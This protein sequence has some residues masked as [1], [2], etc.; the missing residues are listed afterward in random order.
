MT[1][2]SAEW[3]INN[4]HN[5]IEIEFSGKPSA[6][7][8]TRM[9]SAG[10]RWS[11][12]SGV[13][14]ARDNPRTRQ[15]AGE[16][17][18]QGADVGE[19]LSYAEQMQAKKERVEARQERL[20]E[21]IERKEAEADNRFDRAHD[22]ASV[23]PFGQPILIGHHSEKRDR[24]YRAKIDNNMRKGVE[25]QEEA[26]ELG[27]RLDGSR[28]LAA[29]AEDPGAV[30]RKIDKFE[31]ELRKIKRNEQ[32]YSKE[33]Y[34]ALVAK[35]DEMINYWKKILED[36]GGLRVTKNDVKVGDEVRFCGGWSKVVRINAKSVTIDNWLDVKGW[37]Y[38]APYD[39][40]TG[41]R[42]PEE[43]AESPEVKA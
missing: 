11:S 22:M 20:E 29:K 24:N 7:I 16:L 5:G 18:T 32:Y 10:F 33:R 25:A 35:Y 8:R 30:S 26:K 38:L 42:H 3:R 1:E 14:Y 9:K 15:I 12:R 43:E 4:E 37:T 28:R 34:A 19:K 23:I 40:I 39:K 21:R 27:W 13:W 2:P 36:L 31:T 6:D 41:V 17:A